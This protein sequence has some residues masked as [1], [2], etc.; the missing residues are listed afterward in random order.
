VAGLKAAANV[1]GQR[2]TGSNKP[3]AKQHKDSTDV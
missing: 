1:L 3:K 2:V